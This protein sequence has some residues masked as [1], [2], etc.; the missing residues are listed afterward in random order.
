MAIGYIG[1]VNQNRVAATMVGVP[2][3]SGVIRLAPMRGRT[4]LARL[5]A[6]LL[7][8][9]DRSARRTTAQ[10]GTFS[11]AIKKAGIAHID[12]GV[13]LVLS[14][15]LTED[16]TM[17]DLEPGLNLLSALAA[18]G[19][20]VYCMQTLAPG[21]VDP[22][23]E[24]SRGLLGDLRL[25]SAESARAAEVTMT[26]GLI[27][28]YQAHLAAYRQTLRTLCNK[29]GLHFLEATTDSKVADLVMQSLR[30]GGVLG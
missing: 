20:D 14:D 6:T 30:R 4:S 1:L 7:Q 12:R 21:E 25:L 16:G 23:A 13:V 17:N 22:G 3:E 24:R 28:R 19:T 8:S 26:P 29:K 11:T 10:A 27:A 2:N 9:L 18:R 5:G 15:F